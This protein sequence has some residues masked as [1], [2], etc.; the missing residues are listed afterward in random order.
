MSVQNSLHGKGRGDIVHWSPHRKP[1]DTEPSYA[2]GRVLFWS[3]ECPDQKWRP[4]EIICGGCAHEQPRDSAEFTLLRFR[5]GRKFR[6]AMEYPFERSHRWVLS[7]FLCHS[8]HFHLTGWT[9]R[10]AI[11][12]LPEKTVVFAPFVRSRGRY[13]CDTRCHFYKIHAETQHYCHCFIIDTEHRYNWKADNR[14]RPW[15]E[16]GTQQ[17]SLNLRCVPYRSVSSDSITTAVRCH[18]VPSV[19]TQHN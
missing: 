13:S 1:T 7:D 19:P 6:S 16:L 9:E 5:P 8:F 12:L 14:K 2:L 18:V 17:I 15:L 11:K 10:W 3:R 4:A